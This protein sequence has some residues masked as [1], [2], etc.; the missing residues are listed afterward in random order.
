M[1][2][3]DE[4]KTNNTAIA[5]ERRKQT[6]QATIDRHASMHCFTRDLSINLNSQHK[7][8]WVNRLFLESKWLYNAYLAQRKEEGKFKNIDTKNTV[9]P[10]KVGDHFEDRWIV[11]AS[12]QI[13]QQI[14]TRIK[15]NMRSAY[16]NYESGNIKSYDM[17]FI[18][19]CNSVPLKAGRWMDDDD[20]TA[21]TFKIN[22][23][24]NRIKLQ[25]CPFLIRI[26]GGK[27]IPD[28]AEI[29]SGNIVRRRD[30]RLY[31]QVTY[32]VPF[33]DDED[34]CERDFYDSVDGL[35]GVGLDFGIKHNVTLSDGRTFDWCFED[36][37][38]YK[39]AQRR[40][41]LFREWH[42]RK[43]G[44][45]RS[46]RACLDI[47]AREGARL[48]RRKRDAVNQ[49]VGLLRREFGYVVV[50]DEQVA[51]WQ[52]GKYGSD[53]ALSVMGRVLEKLKEASSTVVVGAFERST[54]CCPDCG[55]VLPG[56]LGLDVRSW[57][58]PSCGCVH[59]RDVASARW[60][61]VSGSARVLYPDYP[62]AMDEELFRRLVHI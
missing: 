5:N 50:Q 46:S 23:K 47:M 17:K 49:F 61:L 62:S 48:E 51:S 6:R 13:R 14:L 58:C 33:E 34:S 38:V 21:V 24:K 12:S 55:F 8:D 27:Q 29:A 9:T 3:A 42:R 43:Y 4:K 35:D 40:N 53:V 32:F 22:R 57:T 44:W 20:K 1:D 25:G 18:T 60:M 41:Q 36:S 56:K 30:G 7:R 45:A 15:T 26:N 37:D 39:D 54:G 2:E 10:V 59:D 16:S 11:N 52:S 19:A 31:L 28:D